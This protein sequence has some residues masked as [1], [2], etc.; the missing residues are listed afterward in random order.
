M[1]TEKKKVEENNEA[2]LPSNALTELIRKATKNAQEKAKLQPLTENDAVRLQEMVDLSNTYSTLLKQYMQYTAACLSIEKRIKEVKT[3]EIKMPF[4]VTIS[5]HL[6]Y[7]EPSKDKVIKMLEDELDQFNKA[8]LGVQGQMEHRMDQLV[9][10]MR[11]VQ[12]ILSSRVGNA[13]MTDI[14]GYRDNLQ[15]KEEEV[16]FEKEFD[17]LEK[18][19]LKEIVDTVKE[20]NKQVKRKRANKKN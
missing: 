12:S 14:T 5:K 10:C 9:E 11:R 17:K 6:S 7:A 2:S 20:A 4:M 13:P 1:S 16:V 15:Q 19:E 3:G 18:G 8:R